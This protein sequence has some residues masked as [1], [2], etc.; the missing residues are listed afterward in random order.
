MR[1]RRVLVTGGAGF[2]GSHLTDLLL[3]RGDA[4]TVVDSLT[5]GRR[6]NLP[7]S[8]PRLR[9]IE[10]C[11]ADALGAFGHGER[12]DEIYHL[13]AAVGVRLVMEQPIAAIDTNV[14]Q[15]SA[16]LR[17]AAERGPGGAP[18][19][20]L[21][22]SSSEVYGKPDKQ[23][24]SEDDDVVY[25]PTTK[26]RWSYACTKAI[27][28]YLALAYHQQRGLPAVVARFFNTVGPR[29]VGAYGMVLP[30]FVEAAVA[31]RPLVV[32]GDGRQSRCFC[33]V[34]D[35]VR[36]LPALLGSAGAP[37]RVFNVGADEPVTILALAEL[38]VATLR[39]PSPVRLVPYDAVWTAGFEDLRHRRPDLTRLRAQ[40]SFRPERPL[41]DTILDLAA[42]IRARPAR[43]APTEPRP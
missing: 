39:S 24:F 32:H 38:V 13:A 2:I 23:V 31:G 1:P 42:E 18:C 16:L 30:N 33:D 17:F 22:A 20:T 12:F 41:T 4:V 15:T 43:P 21:I 26:G 28:E 29:Q 3:A 36:A 5:T 10:A 9:F 19:P 40:I 37:G 11:L 35:V 7:E 8:H 14:E 6:S 34:R 25:G 27:D